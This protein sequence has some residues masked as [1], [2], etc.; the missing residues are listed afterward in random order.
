MWKSW[1]T[2]NFESFLK[3]FRPI[4][5]RK[6]ES[7]RNSRE[8]WGPHSTKLAVSQ[9]R[10]RETWMPCLASWQQF[11]QFPSGMMN[12]SHWPMDQWVINGSARIKGS[13][14][15]TPSKVIH[16]PVNSACPAICSFSWHLSV[17]AARAWKPKGSGWCKLAVR[18]WIWN[19]LITLLV[20]LEYTCLGHTVE[21]MA[22]R[23][24]IDQ[25]IKLGW[26]YGV[27]PYNC[28]IQDDFSNFS[29]FSR[30]HDVLNH[31]ISVTFPRSFPPSRGK[32]LLDIMPLPCACSPTT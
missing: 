1:S 15:E 3:V 30:G 6:K 31:R 23:W 10:K 22:Q 4:W 24:L 25:W 7:H 5:P 13:W 14:S 28:Y 20:T 17:A 18:W 11:P 19:I 9:S 2:I 26:K 12:H 21:N 27:S 32:L 29:Y 16:G 8:Q